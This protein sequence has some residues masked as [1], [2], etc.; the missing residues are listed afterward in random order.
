[1]CLI[2]YTAV[3]ATGKE[4]SKESDPVV[5]PPPTISEGSAPAKKGFWNP[6]KELFSDLGPCPSSDSLVDWWRATPIE[7]WPKEKLEAIR[8]HCSLHY[9]G[10]EDGSYSLSSLWILIK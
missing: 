10:V 2:Q 6:P 5:V 1:V 9:F 8:R 4:S 3:N 7:K